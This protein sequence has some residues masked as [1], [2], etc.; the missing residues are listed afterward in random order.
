MQESQVLYYLLH[1]GRKLEELDETK[2]MELLRD[3]AVLSKVIRYLR[4]NHE[5][6]RRTAI[7]AGLEALAMFMGAEDFATYRV[8][9][10][11]VDRSVAL[12]ATFYSGCFPSIK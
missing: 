5:Y 2:V 8:T 4:S 7:D 3:K 11:C 6:L 9:Q 12:T 10:L 1:I